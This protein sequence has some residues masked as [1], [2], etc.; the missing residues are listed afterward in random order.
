MTLRL[1]ILTQM[2][3]AGTATPQF[4][5]DDSDGTASMAHRQFMK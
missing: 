3:K 4:G 1:A 5:I 2:S